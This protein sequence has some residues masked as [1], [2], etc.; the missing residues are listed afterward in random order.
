MSTQEWLKSLKEGDTVGILGTGLNSGDYTTVTVTKVT[1]TG[2]ISV[3]TKDGTEFKFDA[4][5]REIGAMPY[6]TRSLTPITQEMKSERRRK[7]I[8]YWIKTRNWNLLSTEQLE[9]T[10]LEL[11]KIFP[12]GTP[13]K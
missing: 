9:S 8:L 10:Y 12:E 6:H 2:R 1:P 11:K 5:G 7:N 13:T 4:H 3:E